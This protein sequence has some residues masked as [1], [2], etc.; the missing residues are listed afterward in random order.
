M[1]KGKLQLNETGRRRILTPRDLGPSSR[2]YTLAAFL[3]R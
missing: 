3:F 1:S 2:P